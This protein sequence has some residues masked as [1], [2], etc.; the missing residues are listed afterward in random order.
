MKRF[1]WLTPI[2]WVMVTLYILTLT[3]FV[4]GTVFF[5]FRI[6]F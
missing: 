6:F 2:A 1:T 3:F 4:L 5:F